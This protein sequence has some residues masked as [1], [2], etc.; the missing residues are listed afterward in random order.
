MN[1]LTVVDR[2]GVK[3]PE[4]LT[5]D[6]AQNLLDKYGVGGQ[7]VQIPN[8]VNLQKFLGRCTGGFYFDDATTSGTTG[9]P[10]KDLVYYTVINGGVPGNR[11]VIASSHGNNLWIAEVYG[12]V[13]RGWVTFSRPADVT[14]EIT[15]AID[16]HELT[17]DHPYATESAQ[18][19]VELA[20]ATEGASKTNATRAMTSLRTQGLLDTYGI[21]R[22]M[23][24][25]VGVDLALYFNAR[26]CGFYH[27]DAI[28]DY[29]SVPSDATGEWGEVIVTAHEA[30]NYRCLLLTTSTGKMYSAAVT[31]GSFSGWK[32]RIE[33]ADIPL[34]TINQ[35]GI[36]QLNTTVNSTS[37]TQAATASAVKSA[38][39]N[40]ESRVPQ[41]RTVNGLALTN[42]ISITAAMVGAYTR[43]DVDYLINTRVPTTRTIN[44]Y[45]LAGD[46]NFNAG[47]FGTYSAAEIDAKIAAMT[48]N[49]RLGPEVTTGRTAR[50]SFIWYAPYGHVLTGLNIWSK[51]GN[52]DEF[53][54]FYTRPIEI[55]QN[56]A[57]RGIG[58]A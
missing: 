51:S 17:R 2:G 46:L 35:V 10:L 43:A 34:A 37:Q 36:V 21:G 42:N 23:N 16:A 50:E 31:N 52:N 25:P 57:W 39:D 12:D 14:A 41:S 55:F 40:A 13:F 11:A 32:K 6:E 26:S 56:G 38:Y 15:A 7:A 28:N 19:M 29:I 53:R 48:V 3:H 58:Q 1:Q 8:G 54:Y 18:G 30:T 33:L 27:L 5:V 47:H 20:D 45:S 4:I 24:V 44:G 22:S 9:G 49:M